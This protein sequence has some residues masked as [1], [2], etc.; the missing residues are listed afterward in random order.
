MRLAANQHTGPRDMDPSSCV[1]SHSPLEYS[2][3]QAGGM[4]QRRK[5]EFWVPQFEV[6]SPLTPSEV[7]GKTKAAE[8]PW[9]ALEQF[10]ALSHKR[11]S[12]EHH[13]VGNGWFV[14]VHFHSEIF[15]EENK[16][17]KIA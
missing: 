4:L 3:A 7:P 15:D 5:L 2:N 12:G 8:P 9:L 10:S 13:T 14:S 16:V 11:L 17:S 6:R 1:Y